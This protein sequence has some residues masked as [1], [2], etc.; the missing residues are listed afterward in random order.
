MVVAQRVPIGTL[1]VL[2]ESDMKHVVE[3]G[4]LTYL[5]Q[6]STHYAVVMRDG[7]IVSGHGLL[8]AARKAGHTDIPI[9]EL[10]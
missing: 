4:Y 9:Q 6:V 10:G 8:W 1:P 7:E 3:K 5:K 2:T